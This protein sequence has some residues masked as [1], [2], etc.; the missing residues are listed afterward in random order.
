MRAVTKTGLRQKITNPSHERI[1]AAENALNDF[2]EFFPQGLTL[3]IG[4]QKAVWCVV[5]GK[6]KKMFFPVTKH[7]PQGWKER[8]RKLWTLR[9][10]F[11]KSQDRFIFL[12]G[13][14][15]SPLSS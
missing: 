3:Q 8:S 5:M 6:T 12:H 15:L 4:P 11:S 1:Q 14:A 9:L 13:Q 2:V 10:Y 7:W